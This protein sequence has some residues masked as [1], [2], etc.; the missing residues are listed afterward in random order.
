[1]TPCLSIHRY[2]TSKRKK[3]RHWFLSAASQ[4]LMSRL[5]IFKSNFSS[6]SANK[7]FL[8]ANTVTGTILSPKPS[9]T[10][11]IEVL[12][13]SEL[14]FIEATTAVQYSYM[15]TTRAF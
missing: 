2:A 12:R 10:G 1:M 3:N 6:I 9:T 5:V 13:G 7:S 4:T 15:E 8:K 14:V 11:Y